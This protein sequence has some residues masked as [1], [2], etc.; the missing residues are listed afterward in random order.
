M[1]GRSPGIAAGF[2]PAHPVTFK[3][4]RPDSNV[5]FRTPQILDESRRVKKLGGLKYGNC[6]RLGRLAAR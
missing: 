1:V 5:A 2:I 3:T 4:F 6:A